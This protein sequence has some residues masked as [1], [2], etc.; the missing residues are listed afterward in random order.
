VTAPDPAARRAGLVAD[1]DR[2]LLAG[3]STTEL[4]ARLAAHDREQA[5]KAHAAVVAQEQAT[6]ARDARIKA[7][8]QV[9]VA[10]LAARH[11]AVMADIP[12]PPAL[13][14]LMVSDAITDAALTLERA[15]ADLADAVAVLQAATSQ[16]DT[17]TA[18]ATA[19]DAAR[20]EIVARR[21][22]GQ[23]HD[24][25]GAVLEMIRA[26]VEGLAPLATAAGSALNEARTTHAAAVTARARA[27]TALTKAEDTTLID[28]LKERAHELDGLMV[29]VL[30]RLD[31]AERRMHQQPMFCGS[32][33]LRTSLQQ[34]AAARPDLAMPDVLRRARGLPP[35]TANGHLRRGAV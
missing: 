7:A 5:A 11:E 32:N 26:D 27:A 18:R 12:I 6:A 13:D 29:D 15:A 19:L 22:A 30:A 14:I 24:D 33:A 1:I 4:R 16:S 17:V 31:A 2:A 23:P 25:D 28:A 9:I 3:Q 34:R 21:A 8:A 35:A 20:A 10:D